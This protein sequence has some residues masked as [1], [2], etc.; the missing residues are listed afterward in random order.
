MQESEAPTLFLP[1]KSLSHLS[2]PPSVATGEELRLSHQRDD[3][4]SA[5]H[6]MRLREMM[7][8]KAGWKVYRMDKL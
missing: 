2:P 7:G 6:L 8:G 3:V 4:F 1:R 5:S